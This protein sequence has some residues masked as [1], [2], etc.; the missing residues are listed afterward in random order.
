MKTEDNTKSEKKPW[1]MW[2]GNMFKTSLVPLGVEVHTGYPVMK[3]PPEAD[4]II[5]R[6]NQE[7]WTPEQLKYLPDGIRDCEAGHIVIE[8]KYT[9]S[10]NEDVFC[11]ALGYRI[12]YKRNHGLKNH[13]LQAFLVSSKTPAESTLREFGYFSETQAGIRQSSH[14]PMKLVSL[15]SLN[16]LPDEP[17]NAFVKLFATKSGQRLSA[18]RR[19]RKAG[20]ELPEYMRSYIGK[21]LEILKGDTGM[22]NIEFELTSEERKEMALFVK[23]ELTMDEILE[24]FTTEQILDRFT[25]EQIKA[26]LKKIGGNLS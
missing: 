22:G 3:E 21:F 5:I 1:H 8:F 14:S 4:V 17:H 9:E 18:M 7:K 13:Q 15:I 10:V 23:T 2:F 11:T 25:P 6:K 12:F 16:D 26:Y 19:F 20:T 24:N